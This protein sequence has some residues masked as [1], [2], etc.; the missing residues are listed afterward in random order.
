MTKVFISDA[1]GDDAAFAQQIHADLTQ[2]GFAVWWDRESL[3]SVA[4][5]NRWS[6]S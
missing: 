2:A 1:R 6:N 4:L 5:A 3:H